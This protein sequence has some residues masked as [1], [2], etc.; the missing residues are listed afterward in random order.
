M[1]RPLRIL[2]HHRTA[3]NDGMRVHIEQIVAALRE[4][5][6]DVLV[7]GPA[8]GVT[9]RGAGTD[10]LEV[11]T[12]WLRRHLPAFLFELL[13]LA[14]NIPA[15]WRLSLAAR[16]FRPDI[17]YERYN[18]YL[19][20]GLL[21]KWR[22]GLPMLL[23]INSPLAAERAAAGGLSLGYL[24]RT[25]EAALWRG[26]DVALPVTGVL[27][28]MVRQ[29]RGPDG[30]IHV[31]HNGAEL[32]QKAGEAEANAIRR[33]FGIGSNDV[34]LGF[35]GFVR[36]WHG[37]EWAVDALAGLPQNAHLLVVGNGPALPALRARAIERGVAERV[38]FTGQVPHA[39]IAAHM[40]A[41]DV[42]LQPAAVAYASP[43]KLFEYMALE[44][45]IVA[46]DQPNIREVLVN[47]YS[48]LLFKPGN[49]ASF[50]SAV[51]RLYQDSI[52]RRHVGGGARRVV[53]TTPFT[54]TSNANRIEALARD[55]ITTAAAPA[56]TSSAAVAR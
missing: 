30:R 55:L 13:E 3:A 38:H 41:F 27:A 53:E 20:A 2:Y 4:R 7:V 19:L 43:M 37:V 23:E 33:R 10:R 44:R 48:A 18:L 31:V 56:E 34:V 47:G 25:C 14:Y 28:G 29:I 21:L 22:R 16:A 35:A 39:E 50:T 42:A 24:A 49:Q 6:H 40:R 51:T 11:V 26:C 5:G 8:G 36:A 54:W 1:T 32:S 9:S 17:L 45:A 46:P 15:Y 52:L 12:D